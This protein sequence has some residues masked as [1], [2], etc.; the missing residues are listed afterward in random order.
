MQFKLN[1]SL[2]GLRILVLQKE[3]NPQ[4]LYTFNILKEGVQCCLNEMHL[5][6][7]TSSHSSNR[8]E[9][10]FTFSNKTSISPMVI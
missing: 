9:S 6:R 10:T 5:E 1:V 3:P 8:E 4:R 2:S 7:G